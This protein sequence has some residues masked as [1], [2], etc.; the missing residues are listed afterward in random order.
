ML[1]SP[2]RQKK[3]NK[4]EKSLE[5]FDFLCSEK[6]KQFFMCKLCNRSVNG[7]KTSNLTSHL[8]SHPETYLEICRNDT[9]IERK[10]LKL[11]LNCVEL[12]T[13]N[14]RAFRCLNDSAIHNMNEEILKE[15]Q[16]A[17]R[18]LNLRDPHLTEV[19]ETLK[20]VAEKI[21][22]KI[23]NEVKNRALSLLVD[24]VTKRGR[25][26][27]GVS[28]QYIIDSKVIVRSIGMIA[29]DE[30]HTGKYLADLI[31]ERLNL[32]GIHLK[33]IISV[34]TDNGA[35]V[36]RMVKNM[37]NQLQAEQQSTP[38]RPRQR[39]FDETSHVH[40]LTN[41]EKTDQEIEAILALEDLTDDQ[42]LDM[43]FE[44]AECVNDG[45]SKIELQS[46]ENLLNA[47]HSN[48]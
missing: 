6:G 8:K 31:T 11:L 15:L 44:A 27:L 39:V 7:T 21:R 47:I 38:S 34:T 3:I 43:V 41:D 13:V 24:I 35:N 36:L 23:S 9:T 12:I 37:G 20:T 46:N 33:Q 22:E 10:R 4:T 16:A 48:M 30:K 32:L 17:G 26:I 2:A 19:K 42:V 14:G 45:P 40:D 29:L 5:Y 1:D 28:V 18:E 25:S